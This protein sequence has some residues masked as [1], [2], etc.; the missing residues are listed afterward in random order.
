MS[1]F[2]KVAKPASTYTKGAKP[3]LSFSKDAKP[4]FQSL[5]LIADGFV[6]LTTDSDDRLVISESAL[7]WT[8]TSKP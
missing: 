5:L 7:G 1:T 6:L 2:I 8:K 4:G 3:A